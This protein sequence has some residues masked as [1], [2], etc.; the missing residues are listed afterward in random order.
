MRSYYQG[1]RRTKVNSLRR[2]WREGAQPKGTLKDPAPRTQSRISRASMGLEGVRRAARRNRRLRFTALP[3]HISPQLLMDSFYSLQKNAA[4][5]VYGI[6]W[7]KSR[8]FFLSAYPSCT[9]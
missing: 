7:R 8:R 6:T 3:H 5:G 9:G 4:A 1:S 2:W